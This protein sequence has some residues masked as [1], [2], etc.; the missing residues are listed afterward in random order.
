MDVL[1]LHIARKKRKDR[2]RHVAAGRATASLRA[3]R[4]RAKDITSS[5]FFSSYPGK[6]K[7]RGERRA[8]NFI[9]GARKEAAAPLRG[10]KATKRPAS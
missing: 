10:R 6:K 2:I 1:S 9:D 7:R 3:V 8:V 5:S 4:V